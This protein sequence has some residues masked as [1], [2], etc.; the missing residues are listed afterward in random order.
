MTEPKRDAVERACNDYIIML[1]NRQPTIA[2][3]WRAA[4]EW[5]RE[6]VLSAA[7]KCIHTRGRRLDK[8]EWTD[9]YYHEVPCE[10][11]HDA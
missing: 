9:K 10:D 7:P 8:T 3:T 1:N 11:L 6:R 2:D 4:V 5:E